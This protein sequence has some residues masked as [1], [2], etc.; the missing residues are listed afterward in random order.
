MVVVDR[1]GFGPARVVNVGPLPLSDSDV[2]QER[3]G[4][5]SS[6]RSR[7]VEQARLQSHA[8]LMLRVLRIVGKDVDG[9]LG[10]GH[11]I[12][13]CVEVE[14][15]FGAVGLD[16]FLVEV[17]LLVDPVAHYLGVLHELFALLD[18]V[19]EVGGRLE[20]S[21]GFLGQQRDGHVSL[22]HCQMLQHFVEHVHRHVDL[23]NYVVVRFL[24]V[25][26]PY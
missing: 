22:Q 10:V 20:G 8:R 1:G 13:E 5:L 23:L 25:Q 9:V 26:A 16:V 17:D 18:R 15:D 4:V 11:V 14:I 6:L 7:A 21:A 3:E 12:S 24:V 19:V 2:V